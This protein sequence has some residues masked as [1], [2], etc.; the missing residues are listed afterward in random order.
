MPE[1]TTIPIINHKYT[2]HLASTN[3]EV[4]F[5]LC[6]LIELMNSKEFNVWYSKTDLPDGCIRQ[7]TTL[8][9][10]ILSLKLLSL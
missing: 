6:F 10:T 9:F 3:I 8:N 4:I 2:L 1:Y 7:I 5:E